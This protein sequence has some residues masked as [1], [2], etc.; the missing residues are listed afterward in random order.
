VDSPASLR[1]KD[2]HERTALIIDAG[3]DQLDGI[4]EGIPEEDKKAVQTCIEVAQMLMPKG[5]RIIFI[6]EKMDIRFLG[7]TTGTPDLAF[8]DVAS[9]TIAVIDWKFG[10]GPVPDPHDNKQLQAYVLALRN[11]L[12]EMGHDVVQAYLVICQP[13][14]TAKESYRDAQFSAEVFPAWE[15]QIKAGIAAAQK[16]DAPAIPG[17]HCKRSFCEA[18]KN[19]ACPEFKAYSKEKSDDREDI[20]QKKAAFAVSGLSPV[21]VEAPAISFPLVVISEEAIAKAEEYRL[22]AEAAVTDQISANSMGLLLNEIT[23]FESVVE[24]N[25]ET[26][27]RPVLDLGRAIDDAAKQALIPLREAKAQAQKRLVDWKVEQDNN[28]EEAIAQA[29]KTG[30]PAP[31]I[32]APVVIAGVKTKKVPEF[33]VKAFALMPDEFKMTN[34]KVLKAAIETNQWGNG[35]GAVP[36]AWLEVKWVDRASS[37]GR[38]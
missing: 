26:V 13:S 36:P 29:E 8:Y 4:C 30:S 5:K 21:V 3:V 17:P 38:R 9:K 1:G 28:V 27:K 15:E 19:G 23:K 12:K 20:A 22:Q 34:E 11:A 35:K 32:V 24:K 2:L 6:E 18:G 10:R 25:R 37:T 7:S 14:G 16:K 33:S 31:A